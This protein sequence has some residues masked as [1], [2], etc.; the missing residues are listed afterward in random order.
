MRT[1]DH[2]PLFTPRLGQCG[3]LL[4]N[5]EIVIEEIVA[6]GFRLVFALSSPQA[7]L[8]DEFKEK[9]TKGGNVIFP[10]FTN[11]L[12]VL[13]HSAIHYFLS[14]G[15]WN[16]TTEA[17]V[18][19]VPMIFWPVAGD[20]PTNAMQVAAQLDCGFELVQIRTST[21]RTKAYPDTPIVG[22]DKAIRPYERK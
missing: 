10:A 22:S 7:Q 1:S 12:K 18:R 2:I 11:Q 6:H 13:E 8:G 3:S 9:M 17:I 5:P 14:H 21:A 20:Q 19:D 15:G 16:S 4:L